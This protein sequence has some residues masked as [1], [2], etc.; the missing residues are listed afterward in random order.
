MPRSAEREILD[1]ASAAG[2]ILASATHGNAALKA[3]IDA[4]DIV[5][6]GIATRTTSTE[7]TT[8]LTYLD[9]GGEQTLWE[10]TA[11]TRRIIHSIWADTEVLTQNGSFKVS[12]KIDGTNY[13]LWKTVAFTVASDGA[14]NILSGLG[15]LAVNCPIKV[16]YTEGGDEG[17]DRVIPVLVVQS[18]IE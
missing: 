15:A 10:D 8:A 14:M 12:L 2:A 1:Q 7:Y 3:L 16:T 4:G 18:A 5:T 17:A 13:R 6:N 11:V 9:A